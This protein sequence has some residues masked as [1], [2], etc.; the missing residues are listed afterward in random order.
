M[1]DERQ[2]LEDRVI[3]L[4]EQVQLLRARVGELDAEIETGAVLKA[5]R[6]RKKAV[7]DSEDASE[8]ILSWVGQASLLPRI[9][10]LC[11]LLVVAL[12]L[13]TITDNQLLDPQ[14][15]SLLGMVYAGALIAW[16]AYVYRRESPLAPVFVVCGTLLMFSIV[17]ETHARFDSLPTVPAYMLLS[18]VG[19]A[20]A[21]ISYSRKV[22]LP[23][24]AGALGMSIAGVAIDY[25]NPTFPYLAGVLLAANLF[26]VFATRLQRCSWLRWLLLA[27]T[28]LMLQVWGFKLAIFLGRHGGEAIP[29]AMAG[30]LPVVL[31][32]ALVY[33]GIAL[34][35]VVWHGQ[36]RVA[37]FDLALPTLSA[38]WTFIVARYVIHAGL[39]SDTML[40][41]LGVVGALGLFVA[42]HWLGG[43]KDEQ[44]R[45]TNAFS[46]AGAVLLALALPLAIGQTLVALTLISGCAMGLAWMAELWQSGG[47]RV[48]SYLLQLYACAA[49]VLELQATEATSPSFVSA[50]A[51]GAL[52][53]VA[54][55]HFRWAR[56]QA[57]P[58]ASVLFS[59]FDQED[60]SAVLLLLAA[61]IS[62]FFTLRV[63]VFQALRFL[64]I[65]EVGAFGC[66][67]S[68]LINLSAIAL[69]ILAYLRHNKEIRNVAI[70]VIL[71]GGMMVF[72][73]DLLGAKGVSLVISVFSFGLAA[74]V[75]SIILS[76]WQRHEAKA[77]S[78]AEP[79]LKPRRVLKEA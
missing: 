39:G 21:A 49:L 55:C 46:M 54:L 38:G 57:P 61:L 15:G 35:G 53:V 56:G 73:V 8:E 26:G 45:G 71:V 14:V 59:R 64:N 17:V 20:A 77:A 33:F 5:K 79:E 52:A 51:A 66:Y 10:T 37:K 27:V 31:L 22:A 67:Q 65:Q 1:G 50:L 16:G 9:S 47:V 58:A 24:F 32:F 18:I 48:T 11:F 44:A 60:R 40:G 12:A 75:G 78:G 25:P 3:W 69:M 13:R 34:M 23:V 4:E 70:L 76:R 62:G 6:V 42:A 68:V 36:G 43:R 74:A 19:A 29:F 28:M 7:E 41:G 72:F 63:G 2:S 30:F